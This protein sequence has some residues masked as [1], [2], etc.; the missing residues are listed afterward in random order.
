MLWVFKHFFSDNKELFRQLADYYNRDKYRFEFKSVGERKQALKLLERNG[1]DTF[2]VEN[3][4]GY[5]VKL[6]KSSKYASF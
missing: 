1:F 5:V 4:K 6:D 3:L 2:P